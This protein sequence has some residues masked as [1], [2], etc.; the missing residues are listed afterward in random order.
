[1]SN[2]STQSGKV[3]L[4]VY[5]TAIRIFWSNNLIHADIIVQCGAFENGVEGNITR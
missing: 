2:T 1:M 3:I 5:M 4:S